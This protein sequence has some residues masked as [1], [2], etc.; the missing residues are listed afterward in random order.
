MSWWYFIPSRSLSTFSR[1]KIRGLP[2]QILFHF[3]FL[4]N[5]T[6]L[7]PH[8]TTWLLIFTQQN[9]LKSFL[10]AWGG[11]KTWFE[12]VTS[13]I[14]YLYIHNGTKKVALFCNRISWDYLW[15]F[16]FQVF[17]VFLRSLIGWA[18]TH[19]SRLLSPPPFFAPLCDK[20]KATTYR[21][22]NN[23][24]LNF[25]LFTICWLIQFVFA[26]ATTTTHA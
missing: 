19:I 4:Q 26:T 5:S 11:K 13:Y 6:Q 25:E 16:F 23:I 18:H 2:N 12:D 14:H 20:N 3:L 21:R 7:P 17:S 22:P 8:L 9:Q 15:L 10:R 1:C 24:S